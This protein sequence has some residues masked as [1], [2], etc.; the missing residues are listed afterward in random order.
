MGV[1]FF[2]IYLPTIA[3]FL[4]SMQSLWTRDVCKSLKTFRFSSKDSASSL[5][6]PQSYLD[7]AQALFSQSSS[8]TSG[9]DNIEFNDVF[10]NDFDDDDDDGGGGGGGDMGDY[11]NMQFDNNPFNINNNAIPGI[12]SEIN[13]LTADA[14]ANG[15]QASGSSG[16]DGEDSEMA[17]VITTDG[18]NG[19]EDG[20][21]G[22]D[23]LDMFSYFDKSLA[24]G[25]MGPEHWRPRRSKTRGLDRRGVDMRRR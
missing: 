19:G 14:R 24:K 25:W 11:D 13:H 23:G 20:E 9:L 12:L 10:S 16:G 22:G 21:T 3:R 5:F 6:N 2:L 15:G 8:S 7:S 17:R 1:A 18:N 4:D